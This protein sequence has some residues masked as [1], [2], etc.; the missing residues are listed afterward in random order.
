MYT[1]KPKSY[2]RIELP[3]AVYQKWDTNYPYSFEYSKYAEVLTDNSPNAEPYWVNLH[4]PLWNVTLFISYKSVKNNLPQLIDDAIFFTTKQIPKADDMIESEVCDS[5][6]DIYGTVY[7]IT[8]KHVA[9]TY[10]FWL[11]DK[12]KHFFRGAL[13]FNVVPNNDSIAPV[14]EYVKK[15]MEHLIHTFAWKN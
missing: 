14:L 11:T 9:C 10:Q 12:E 1:P 4:Y 5:I 13:Y 7:E 8:G 3:K 6:N 15:D 2:Y